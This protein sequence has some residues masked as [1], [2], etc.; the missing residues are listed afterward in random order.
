MSTIT[1]PGI[2]DGIPN[3]VYHAD[4]VPG[5]SLSVSG[6]KLLLSPSTPAHYRHRMA[7]PE[8]KD[9]FDYGTAA[10]SIILEGDESRLVVVDKPDW[11]TKEAQE[12]KAAA[13]AK[14][15]TPLLTKDLDQ[16]RE[17]AEVQKAHAVAGKLFLNGKPEQSAFWPDPQTGV[18]RRAR[19]D[20]L[21][22]ITP[23]K[24]LIIPDYK[25]AVS[26]DAQKFAKSAA[27]FRYHMQDPWYLDAILDMGLATDVAFVFVVQEKTAP[28]AVNVI[29]L[30]PQYR[31]LGRDLNRRAIETYAHCKAT[32]TW[33]AYTGVTQVDP[34]IYAEYEAERILENAA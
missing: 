6:A 3:E 14:G 15:K 13:H 4:P 10:H 34:P 24:R 32:N 17:M 7:N 28:Y 5:G 9:I 12:A 16:V 27:D 29:E 30:S 20:W 18:W 26:A 11:R 21:P 23:G 1:A 22:P 8:H 19:F 25:T 33:P 31:A 2:Y